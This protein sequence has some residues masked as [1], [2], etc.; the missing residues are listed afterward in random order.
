MIPI[1]EATKATILAWIPHVLAGYDYP[2]VE[3]DNIAPDLIAPG[4]HIL[5]LIS[6]HPERGKQPD[7]PHSQE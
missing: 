6:G 3:T 4:Y 7:H 2:L 1:P 5:L